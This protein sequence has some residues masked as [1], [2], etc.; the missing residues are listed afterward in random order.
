MKLKTTISLL[1]SLA[2]VSAQA[3][4]LY[5]IP[6]ETDETPLPIE[7]G[8][9]LAA[10][11]DSNTTPSSPG[12]DDETFSINPY[13]ETKFVSG[14]SQTVWDVYAKLGVLYYLD[15]PVAAGSDD[16]YGQV[17][18]GANLTH[19]FNERL[20]L[21]SRN[22]VSYEL[23][24]DYSYGFATNRQSSEFI[25]WDT[26]NSIGYRWTDRLAT[27]T[28]LKLTMLDYADVT[29]T[30]R[31]TWTAY[32]QFRYVLSPQTVGTA[33]IRYAQTT[34]DGQASDSTDT[35]LLLGA[36]HR[37]S[38]STILI[39]NVG[40]QIREVDNVNGNDGTSPYFEIT[41]RTQVNQQFTLSTFARYGAEVNDTVV[42][43]PALAEYD[44]RLTLRLGSQAN[45]QVSQK[46]SLFSG[47]DVISTSFEEGRT[48]PGGVA[49]ADQDETL[50]NA[51]IGATLE[52]TEYLDGTISYNFT[53]ADSDLPNRSYDRSRISVGLK[54]EF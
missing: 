39:A 42:N 21:T 20:Q 4:G 27:Y 19:R 51:Y 46:L 10:I 14:T 1:S 43:L 45:Y 52:L 38:P 16:V 18:I 48:I 28:G 33:S 32:N 7:W 13:V 26:D 35:Y 53:N 12:P 49:V 6:S 25:Y 9:G 15:E 40:A 54:A 17:R 24:P 30:D 3:G 22:F 47:I 2:A 29:N 37:F 8:V 31:F 11:W 44:S 34:A 50:M 23:E 41:L 5:Y 36:E